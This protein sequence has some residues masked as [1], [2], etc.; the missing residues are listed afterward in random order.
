MDKVAKIVAEQ[1]DYLYQT[2]DKDHDVICAVRQKIGNA[3]AQ[4]GVC[5]YDEFT[6]IARTKR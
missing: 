5:S 4:Q 3:L 1:F 6:E 2:H